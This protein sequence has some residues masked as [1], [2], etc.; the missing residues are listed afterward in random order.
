MKKLT[1]FTLV[2]LGFSTGIA[3]AGTAPPPPIA[4]PALDS[5]GIL[6]LAVLVPVVAALAYKNKK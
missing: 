3:F 6:G 4:T 5:W 2:A 1:I